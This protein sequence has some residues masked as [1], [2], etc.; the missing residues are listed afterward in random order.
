MRLLLHKILHWE[1]W[2]FYIVYIPIY[3]LWA[4]YALRQRSIFFFNASNPTITNGGFMMESKKEIYDLIPQQYYPKTILAKAGT[5]SEDIIVKAKDHGIQYPL[6]IKPDIGLRGSAVKKIDNAADLESY[7]DKADFDCIVQDLIPYENEIG[8]FYVRYP[9][10]NEG[11]ITGIVAKE[12]LIVTGDGK[13]T[14]EAL[15]KENPRYEL[16]LKVLRKEYGGKLDEI[17]AVGEKVNLVPYGNHARGA[18]FIDRTVWATPAL[19]KVMNGICLQI[20]GFYFGRIDLMYESLEA[21]ERG[22]KFSIVELNGAASEPTHIYDPEHSLFFAW[23]ELI[24]HIRY[25]Y[26]ISVE[27]HKN[28]APYL[29]HKKGMEQYRLHNLHCTK[30]VNF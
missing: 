7:V 23:K 24:R 6:I 30:I 20:D 16:Q 10:E 18:K 15:I 12:F 22:E 26:E 25:M 11:R 2:P 19:N 4:Y 13:S 8:I 3:F 5:T 28:G 27:N 29:S 9:H 1:Y 21:L 17:P 14:L